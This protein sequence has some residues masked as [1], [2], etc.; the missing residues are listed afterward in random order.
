VQA[1][2]KGEL[3][4]GFDVCRRVGCLLREA[5]VEQVSVDKHFNWRKLSRQ[6][7]D[8]DD[9]GYRSWR[10]SR[11]WTSKFVFVAVGRTRR[12][13][14]NKKILE[15]LQKCESRKPL[16]SKIVESRKK[17]SSTA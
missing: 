9:V 1:A 11:I 4:V 13:A 8:D 12:S 7:R 16:S 10:N 15:T 17:K 2:E 6:R 3:K 5:A 14:L